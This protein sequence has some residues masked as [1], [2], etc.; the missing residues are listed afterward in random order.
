MVNIIG[1]LEGHSPKFEEDISVADSTLVGNVNVNSG[2]KL[3]KVTVRDDETDYSGIHLTNTTMEDHSMVHCHAPSKTDLAVRIKNSKAGKG[4]LY[5]GIVGDNVNL[6]AFGVID[7]A[8]ATN[9]TVGCRGYIW[10]KDIS[11]ITLNDGDVVIRFEDFEF[12]HT[13][14]GGN[15]DILDKYNQK[16]LDLREKYY[17]AILRENTP[18]SLDTGDDSH[19]NDYACLEGEIGVGQNANI[20]PNAVVINSRLGFGSNAQENTILISTTFGDRV[21]GAH[22]ATI[23]NGKVGSNSLMMFNAYSDNASYGDSTVL[24]ANSIHDFSTSDERVEL[25]GGRLY[26]GYA[27]SKEEALQNSVTFD[28]IKAMPGGQA[29]FDGLVNRMNNSIL[30]GNGADYV[31]G[32]EPGLA[33]KYNDR[34]E[35]EC[36]DNI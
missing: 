28:Q 26:F 18:T 33:Q 31:P 13:I 2:T 30:K 6:G 11:D 9:V 3:S 10:Q 21:I 5:H 35:F 12:K 23:L 24:C 17:S 25:E 15:K 1:T 27:A 7:L 4:S 14:A 22:G 36:R 32:S 16:Q 8:N 34:I 20:T 19:T 29:F